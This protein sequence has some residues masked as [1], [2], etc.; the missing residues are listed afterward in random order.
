MDVQWTSK[1][2]TKYGVYWFCGTIS[3]ERGVFVSLPTP[4]LVRV[5]DPKPVTSDLNSLGVIQLESPYYTD[6]MDHWNGEWVGP[7]EHPKK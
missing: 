4:V 1:K 2:P 7:I 6:F 3:D 5:S